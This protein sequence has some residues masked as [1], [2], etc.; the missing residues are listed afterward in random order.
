MK[1][2]SVPELSQKEI[3]EVLMKYFP[4]E[5]FESIKFSRQQVIFYEKETAEGLYFI[6]K[7]SI[8]IFVRKKDG[9][10]EILRVVAAPAVIGYKHLLSATKFMTTAI[11]LEQVEVKMV[12]REMFLYLVKN[13]SDLME[14]FLTLLCLDDIERER[15]LIDFE[16]KPVRGR[17]ADA[18]LRLD[19]LF[20]STGSGFIYFSRKEMAG[21]I[22]SVRETTT[23][24]ISEFRQEKIIDTSNN[25]IKILNR[26]KLLDI[27]NLYS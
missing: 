11:A 14:T 8:K 9:R 18:L 16:Y 13:N 2:N 20:G 23:R 3:Q 10:E 25:R 22:G 27:S 15:Q 12:P 7:G 21:Y 5:E 26:K 6:T 24:L 19:K 1:N 4:P 17:L